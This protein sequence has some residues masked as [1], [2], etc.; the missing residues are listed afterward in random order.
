MNL[1]VCEGN[2]LKSQNTEKF[3]KK[4]FVD[5]IKY[6]DFETLNH[7]E[8]EIKRLFNNKN[9]IL[10]SILKENF[11]IGYLIGEFV[12]LGEISLLDDRNVFY[13]TYIFVEKNYRDKK[14]GQKLINKLYSFIKTKNFIINGYMLRFNYDNEKLKYFYEKNNFFKDLILTTNSEFDVFFKK[15]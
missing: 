4:I 5:F 1:F 15:M 10:I 8:N 13:I 12:N 3:Q 9:T 2:Y 6:K 14:Y 7:N 11:V